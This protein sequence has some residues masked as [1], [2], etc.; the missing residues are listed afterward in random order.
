[1]IIMLPP[2]SICH[3][4]PQNVTIMIICSATAKS[5]I[6]LLT[7]SASALPKKNINYFQP[8][9]TLISYRN[10]LCRNNHSKNCH[11]HRLS[12]KFFSKTNLLT[13]PQIQ[14]KISVLSGFQQK[15]SCLDDNILPLSI[16][17]LQYTT[18]GPTEFQN[19]PKVAIFFEN[20]EN[21]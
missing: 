3:K 15:T 2:S 17:H 13:I 7:A 19:P 10:T 4:T 1:M 16:H 9:L 20:L 11:S 5:S 6:P 12:H 8:S 18:M 21:S 14:T